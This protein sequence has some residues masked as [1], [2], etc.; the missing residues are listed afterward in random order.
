M[1]DIFTRAINKGARSL[2]QLFTRMTGILDNSAIE[3]LMQKELETRFK[4]Y[5]KT[6]L[7]IGLRYD[8]GHRNWG[9]S[10]E[11]YNVYNTLINMDYSVIFLDYDRLIQKYGK[12]KTSQM[13][14]EAAYYY[15]PDF[16]FY[17]HYRDWIDNQV[18]KEI[19]KF[20]KTIIWLA[21]DH[22][23]Y[24]E[25]RPVWKLFNLIVTTDRQS[26]DRRRKEGFEN[27]FFSQWGCNHFLYKDLKMQRIYDVTFA[28]RA[29]GKRMDF[30]KVL[31]KKC[32]AVKTFGQGWNGTSRIPQSDLIKIFNQSKISLNISFASTETGTITDKR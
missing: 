2:D 5:K 11:F 15:H 10:Y 31:E 20:S 1:S 23:R 29:Y 25:T 24:E 13:L 7:Y 30:I 28:G 32:I 17:F 8:Y 21:D 19:S 22:W 3:V 16:I 27:V 9:L 14:R 12:E 18:W 6:I 26:F 4:Q